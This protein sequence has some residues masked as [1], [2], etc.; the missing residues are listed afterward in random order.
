MREWHPE[1]LSGFSRQTCQS[2]RCCL[3]AQRWA[4]L[5]SSLLLHR[6]EYAVG[7]TTTPEKE[8]LYEARVPPYVYTHIQMLSEFSFISVSE[9]LIKG[10]PIF[11]SPYFYPLP[12]SEFRWPGKWAQRCLKNNHLI[13]M[14]ASYSAASWHSEFPK[15]FFSEFVP[16]NTMGCCILHGLSE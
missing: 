4:S 5:Q 16:L 14:S 2:V 3:N 7:Q 12:P 9:V 8:E 6:P 11:H 13:L 15:C 10:T 1:S